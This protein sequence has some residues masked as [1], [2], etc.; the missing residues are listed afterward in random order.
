MKK[1]TTYALIILLLLS[2]NISYGNVLSW[3]KKKI[4]NVTIEGELGVPPH[5]KVTCTSGGELEC[6]PCSSLFK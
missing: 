2:V 3:C 6:F 1:I 5:V 4:W